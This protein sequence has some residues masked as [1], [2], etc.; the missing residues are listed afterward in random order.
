MINRMNYEG[1]QNQRQKIRKHFSA[2]NTF[3]TP[4]KKR[5]SREKFLVARPEPD[6]ELLAEGGQVLSARAHRQT[7]IRVHLMGVTISCIRQLAS[8]SDSRPHFTWA[9]SK[10]GLRAN[11]VFLL[12][13]CFIL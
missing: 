8:Q 10:T 11:R 3:S 2:K 9:M 13:R 4:M 1:L 12:I 5:P 7:P 6:F